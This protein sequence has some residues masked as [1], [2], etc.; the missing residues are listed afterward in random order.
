MITTRNGPL[1]S[2]L[3]HLDDE[4]AVQQGKKCKSSPVAQRWKFCCSPSGR[5]REP[6]FCKLQGTLANNLS[7]SPSSPESFS[8]SIRF[9]NFVVSVVLR[10]SQKWAAMPACLLG[11]SDLTAT[12]RSKQRRRRCPRLLARF[13]SNNDTVR[14]HTR[15]PCPFT[16]PAGRWVSN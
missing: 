3:W 10:R 1:P 14:K 4:N 13:S 9:S 7:C 11:F 8:F 2:S 5:T 12:R 15:R 16:P 6:C